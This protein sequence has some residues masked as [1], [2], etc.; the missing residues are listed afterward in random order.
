MANNTPKY[1]SKIRQSLQNIP[2][3]L[4]YD[5]NLDVKIRLVKNEFVRDPLRL[6]VLIKRMVNES[7]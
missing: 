6:A 4:F 3:D 7:K 2:D 1:S 5:A